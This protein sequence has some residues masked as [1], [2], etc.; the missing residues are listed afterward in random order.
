MKVKRA[1]YDA[2]KFRQ[3]RRT[4]EKKIISKGNRLKIV[5]LIDDIN[6]ESELHLQ[7]IEDGEKFL[8]GFKA[9]YG[10]ITG[11]NY[12]IA[13]AGNK[14]LK[15]LKK[16]IGY[17]GELLVLECTSLGLGTCWIGETYHKSE[18]IKYL[19]L[20]E[21]EELVCI[22]DNE[23]D[24]S[25][26]KL[27]GLGIAMGNAISEVKNIADYITDTNKRDGVAKAIEKFILK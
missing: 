11:T 4:Y 8:T 22:G 16:L 24:I 26:I 19:N 9:S 23:N 2:I 18:C 20:S 21:E 12:F 3:S 27:A 1:W 14:N 5:Q 15:N 6:N 25:M 7:F 10:M 13:L 17:Y